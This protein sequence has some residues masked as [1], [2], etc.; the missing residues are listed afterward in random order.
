MTSNL[1]E[2][3]ARDVKRELAYNPSACIG[4]LLYCCAKI[5]STGTILPGIEEPARLTV[6]SVSK[7]KFHDD[8]KLK[9]SIPALAE[10]VC[11]Q[12]PQHAVDLLCLALS[13]VE[14]NQEQYASV[15]SIIIVLDSRSKESNHAKA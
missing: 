5:L 8:V 6:S 1:F 14:L 13:L 4:T 2:L 9:S 15:F 3:A 7:L 10:L 11:D 12:V